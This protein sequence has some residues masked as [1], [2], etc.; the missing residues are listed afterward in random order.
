MQQIP[1]RFVLQRKQGECS[2]FSK[3]PETSVTRGDNWWP[4]LAMNTPKGSNFLL[5]PFI[6]IFLTTGIPEDG[7]KEE[8]GTA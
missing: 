8:R 5:M 1:C 2:V 3:L 6:F 7:H 4:F